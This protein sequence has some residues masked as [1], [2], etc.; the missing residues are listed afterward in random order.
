MQRTRSGGR[1]HAGVA[2]APQHGNE[3]I[4]AVAKLNELKRVAVSAIHGPLQEKQ[5]G[6]AQQM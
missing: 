2:G 5:L 3:P 6:T 4:F 1:S